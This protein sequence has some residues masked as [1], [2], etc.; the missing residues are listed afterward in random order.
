M[1]QRVGAHPIWWAYTST[2]DAIAT[3]TGAGF[4]S[5][6]YDKGVKKYDM[7]II[8]DGGSTVH[9]IGMFYSVVASSAATLAI[10]NLSSTI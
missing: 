1:G 2:A 6:G 8:T 7:C 9:S 5:D 3:T 10:G 4:F